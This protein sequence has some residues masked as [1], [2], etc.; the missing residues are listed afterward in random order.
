[1]KIN[2]KITFNKWETANV[3]IKGKNKTNEK[4]SALIFIYFLFTLFI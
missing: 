2:V 3:E 1:M 4:Q